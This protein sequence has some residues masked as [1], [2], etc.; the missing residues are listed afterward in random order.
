MQV[1]VFPDAMAV[2]PAFGQVEPAFT[3][4]FTGEIGVSA[5]ETIAR[6]AIS[7]LSIGKG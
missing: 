1:K 7:F 3:A 2:L 4:A 6:G 5:R